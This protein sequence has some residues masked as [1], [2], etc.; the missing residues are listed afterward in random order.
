VPDLRSVKTAWS[1]LKEMLYPW[2]CAVKSTR[3][4]AWPWLSSKPKGDRAYAA[5]NF[6]W[7]RGEGSD[8]AVGKCLVTVFPAA[9]SPTAKLLRR[10]ENGRHNSNTINVARPAVLMTDFF[11]RR[12][13]TKNEAWLCSGQN[14]RTP[15]RNMSDRRPAGR[16]SGRRLAEPATSVQLVGPRRATCIPAG[17][18]PRPSRRR[19]CAE[20]SAELEDRQ[21][22]FMAPSLSTLTQRAAGAYGQK[23]KKQARLPLTPW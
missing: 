22:D 23:L 1:G 3:E 11:F 7:S 20:E 8:V 14:S 13:K 6:S 16:A 15:F 4:S 10:I 19:D 21:K 9:E 17:K 18:F 2:P 5:K 12:P